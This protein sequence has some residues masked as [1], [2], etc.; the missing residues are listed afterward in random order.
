MRN[1]ESLRRGSRRLKERSTA[2]RSRSP[3]L[4]NF[5]LPGGGRAGALC[6]VARTVARRAERAVV[7]LSHDLAPSP[8]I[9]AYLNRLSDLLFVAARYL[10]LQA[11]MSEPVWPGDDA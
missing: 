2:W 4:K 8:A 10:N 11:G 7:R 6:H 3:P 9:H 5:I 1:L